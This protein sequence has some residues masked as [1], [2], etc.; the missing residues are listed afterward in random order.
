MMSVD[1][2]SNW[3]GDGMGGK[4]RPRVLKRSVCGLISFFGLE[5]QVKRVGFV[6]ALD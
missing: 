2:Y 6:T 3:N 5:V 4:L 1:S